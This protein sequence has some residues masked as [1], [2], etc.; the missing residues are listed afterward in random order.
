MSKPL[1]FCL[2]TCV[3]A[4]V[5]LVLAV[6]SSSADERSFD[7]FDEERYFRVVDGE[8]VRLITGKNPTRITMC[9]RN[10]ETSLR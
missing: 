2:R 1:V 4:A 9:T 3:L 5:L 6:G 10:R 7:Y 8:L